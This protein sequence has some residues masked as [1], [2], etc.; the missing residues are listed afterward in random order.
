MKVKTIL[1]R[2]ISVVCVPGLLNSTVHQPQAMMMW[3]GASLESESC[4]DDC[5]SSLLDEGEVSIWVALSFAI[6]HTLRSWAIWHPK[7]KNLRMSGY[8]EWKENC[9]RLHIAENHF[10]I[11]Y[12]TFLSPSLSNCKQ[13]WGKQKSS[14]HG[15]KILIKQPLDLSNYLS[16]MMR[17]VF[18]MNGMIK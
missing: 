3:M 9:F 13:L 11:I 15:P 5:S 14:I 10:L 4:I 16:Q 6:S 1:T 2:I 18:Q 8:V 17:A 12:F 7:N